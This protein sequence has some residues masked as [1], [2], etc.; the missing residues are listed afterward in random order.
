MSKK[1]IETEKMNWE[2]AAA[3]ESASHIQLKE[4][5]DHF[6]NG[7]FEKPSSGKYFDSINPATAKKIAAVAEGNSKMSIKQ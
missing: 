2:Y 4:K 6:I 7:K 1:K 3:P 5:Y